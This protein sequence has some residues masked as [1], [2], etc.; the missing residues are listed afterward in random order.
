MRALVAAVDVAD[1]CDVHIRLADSV[2]RTSVQSALAP[3]WCPAL[4]DEGS[5]VRGYI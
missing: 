5:E 2:E 1:S 3:R 4:L